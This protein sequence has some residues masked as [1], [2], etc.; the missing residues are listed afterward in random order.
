MDSPY[1]QL[2]QEHRGDGTTT[3]QLQA[4]KPKALFIWCNE[5]AGYVRRLARELGV[6][7]V[8]I[9]P[10]SALGSNKQHLAELEISEIILDHAL[11][12][13]SREYKQILYLQS[14]VRV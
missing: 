6:K 2:K 13:D 5:K 4:A 9:F 11:V 8:Y 7:D 14:R 10:R 3:R 1:S 12:P